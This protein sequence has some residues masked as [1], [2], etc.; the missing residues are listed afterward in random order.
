VYD[1]GTLKE[2]CR[3][4][5][6]EGHTNKIFCVKYDNINPHLIYSG[7]WDHKVLIWD[8]RKPGDKAVGCII[9]PLICGDAIDK[10]NRTQ[11]LL[12]GSHS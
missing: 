8:V 6:P 9:G 4:E 1:E 10:D 12:T 11:S 5:G 2:V 7:G 3:L